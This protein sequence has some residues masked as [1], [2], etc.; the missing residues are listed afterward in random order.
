MYTKQQIIEEIR[1]IANKLNVKSLKQKDFKKHSKISLSTV[2]YNFS[3]WNDAVKEAG[4]IPIDS[5]EVIS[6]RELIDN[7]K[8]LSD[9]IRIYK[10]YGREP[11]YSLVDAKG[12]YSTTPYRNRWNNIQEAFLIAK[13]KF[14]K[15]ISTDIQKPDFEQQKTENIKVIPKTVKPK[16]AKKRRIIF[17]EPIDFRGLR[18]APVNEQGVVYLFGMISHELGFLI[19]SIRTECPDCEGKRCFDKENNRW[20]HVRI[21]FE[22]RSSNFKEHG[23]DETKCDIIVCWIHDWDDCPI[24]VLELKSTIQYLS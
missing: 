19:E 4:L 17:G 7:D 23:H 3:T 15:E 1:K 9:L 5:T 10:E 6:K 21:E 18:F 13:Q 22:Y 24:E 8:L 20:E 14:P 11:T 16:I 2:R 12:K